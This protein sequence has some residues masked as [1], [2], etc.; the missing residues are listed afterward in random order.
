MR[1]HRPAVRVQRRPPPGRR[2]DP[3]TAARV[4]LTKSQTRR[5]TSAISSLA[6]GHVVDHQN[7]RIRSDTACGPAS[8]EVVPARELRRTA[9]IEASRNSSAPTASRRNAAGK[10]MVEYQLTR[11]WAKMA[12]TKR[13]TRPIAA[14]TPMTGTAIPTSNPSA[15]AALSA[16]SGN[17]Q[18]GGTP[19]LA[20]LAK[21]LSAC[22]KSVMAAQMLAAAART[23]TTT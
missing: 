23:A 11:R 8:R 17:S 5:K 20:A 14:A 18:D 1:S 6:Y 3:K 12:Q 19:T 16:P 9:H 22:V 15:P 4:R 10:G 7:N 2:I 13:R 21:A